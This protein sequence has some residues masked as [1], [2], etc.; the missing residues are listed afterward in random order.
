VSG[1]AWSILGKVKWVVDKL[2]PDSTVD[3]VQDRWAAIYNFPRKQPQG[4]T[5][6]NVLRVTGTIGNAVPVDSQLA[7]ADGT[8]YHVT[9]ASAVVG[10]SGYVDVS[11]A[12]DSK[13]QATNK[14]RRRDADLQPG[15]ERHRR[16]RHAAAR[17]HGR[18]RP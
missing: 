4:S 17:A 3:W 2:L 7:H 14:A 12:A 8:L 11:I 5:G 15:A 13:G 6:T 9:S 1:T 16:R 18:H 10:G